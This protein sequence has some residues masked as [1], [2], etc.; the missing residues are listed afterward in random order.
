MTPKILS[1]QLLQPSPIPL[2]L[3]T[4]YIH[5][6]FSCNLILWEPYMVI[7][8]VKE[9]SNKHTKTPNNLLNDINFKT[10][11]FKTHETRI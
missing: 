10:I 4:V 6:S 1:P 9:T 5:P 8:L 3:F 7:K 2:F 11:T